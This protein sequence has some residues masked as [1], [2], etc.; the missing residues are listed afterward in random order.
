MKKLLLLFCIAGLLGCKNRHEPVVIQKVAGERI[1]IGF[2]DSVYSN[3]LHEQRKVWIY[4]PN[5]FSYSVFKGQ[6]HYPVVY[7]LDGDTH[8]HAFTGILE[9]LSE[10]N[11]NMICPDMI[12]VGILNTD[13]TRDLTPTRDSTTDPHSGGADR[14]T[15]FIEKE[16]ILHIDSLYHPSPFRMLIGHSYGGLTVIN[17]LLHH[18]EPFNAFVAIDP[19]LSWNNHVMLKQ[20]DSVLATADFKSK[21]LFIGVANTMSADMTLRRVQ[22]DT[23]AENR[24]IRSILAF[25]NDLKENAV[26]SLNW[27]YNYYEDEDHYSVPI[28]ASYDALHFIFRDYAFTAY[29]EL[30][31]TSITTDS[32]KQIVA[33]HFKYASCKL[34]FE[35]QPPEHFLNALANMFQKEGLT[36]RAKAFLQWNLNYYPNSCNACECMGDFCSKQNNNAE[37]LEFYKKAAALNATEAVNEKIRQLIKSK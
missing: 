16:L 14:F 25:V 2:V 24:H 26:K 15:E 27:D 10:E 7:L 20:T 8:F 9:H 11:G 12:V 34:G 18:A 35:M 36:E 19:S 21:K 5:S 33:S 22:Q 1:E 17:T 30:F 32:A 37:A 28:R 4:I 13:R 6:Q 29:N 23:S 31:D 3:I